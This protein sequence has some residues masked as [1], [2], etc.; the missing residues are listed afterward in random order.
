MNLE[1]SDEFI[2]PITPLFIIPYLKLEVSNWKDKKK[3][4]LELMDNCDLGTDPLMLTSFFGEEST[5]QNDS[6]QSIFE[7]ELNNMKK[8]FGFSD[9]SIKHS[10]FQE[11]IKNMFHPIHEHCGSN[12]M[13]SSVCYI[14]YD[15][16]IHTA[17]EFISPFMDSLSYS[18]M[19]F[20]PEVTEG[21]II[22]FPANV[23][24]QT[25]P[26]N[27]DKPRKIVSFNLEVK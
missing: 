22:F 10:W 2:A 1:Q 9:C 7:E 16:S 26:S 6:I 25:L 20:T 15:P 24:H 11:Q 21:T 18:H 17:T 5:N 13:M 27:S 19:Y 14:E 12:V 3:K 4:L 8:S 23:L